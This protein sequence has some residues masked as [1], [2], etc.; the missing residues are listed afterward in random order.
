[1]EPLAIILALLGL[2]LF[3][4]NIYQYLTQRSV[5]RIAEILYIMSRNV[6][7]KAA[8]VRRDRKDVEIVEAHLFDISTATRSILRTLGR[9]NDSLGPDPSVELSP[10]PNRL[11]SDSL[12]RLADNIL[13]AV[14]EDTPEAKGD[15]VVDRALDRF[16]QKVPT[17]DRDAAK[18]IVTAVA[19]QSERET[20][21]PPTFSVSEHQRQ[22]P[23][24]R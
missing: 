5:L 18:K 22:Y 12:L 6:L 13:Y 16:M 3:I 19:R 1:M 24:S 8:E 11:D 9:S 20:N 4:L 21:W 17:L 15:E 2:V 23:N 7:E 10:N 14:L